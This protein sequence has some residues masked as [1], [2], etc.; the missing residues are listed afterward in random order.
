MRHGLLNRTTFSTLYNS[1]PSLYLEIIPEI[2]YTNN[3][4]GMIGPDKCGPE[5][6]DCFWKQQQTLKQCSRH[7]IS[8]Q[9]TPFFVFCFFKKMLFQAKISLMPTC[10]CSFVN[11][12]IF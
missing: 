9:D 4:C 2:L 1:N 12:Q 8:I 11:F 5:F 6:S 7:I 10:M 3:T